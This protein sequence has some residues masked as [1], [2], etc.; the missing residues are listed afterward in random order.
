MPG[1]RLPLRGRETLEPG[2]VSGVLRHAAV[3][4]QVSIRQ[5]R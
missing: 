5:D 2:E 1:V 4:A 3:E